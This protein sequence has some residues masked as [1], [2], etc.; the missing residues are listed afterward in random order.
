VVNLS[1]KLL[2]ELALRYIHDRILEVV[3]ST[4]MKNYRDAYLWLI[5]TQ[6]PVAMR[7][8][9]SHVSGKPLLDAL[10]DA[11]GSNWEW[12]LLIADGSLP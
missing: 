6:I 5:T 4:S 10:C 2:E 7:N 1:E 9:S 8:C 3:D 12:V 11:Y